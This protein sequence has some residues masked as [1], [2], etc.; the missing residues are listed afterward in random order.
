MYRKR[1]RWNTPTFIIGLTSTLLGGK[2]TMHVLKLEQL[3]L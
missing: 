1:E 2:E 3:F